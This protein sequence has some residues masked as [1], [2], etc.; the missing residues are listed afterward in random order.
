MTFYR[1]MTVL[2]CAV[3][4]RDCHCERCSTVVTLYR[5][6]LP[7]RPSSTVMELVHVATHVPPPFVKQ[8]TSKK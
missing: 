5:L 2:S 8:P 1:I 3:V 4:M 7:Y 6:G